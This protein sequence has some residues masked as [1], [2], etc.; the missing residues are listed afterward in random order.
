[1]LGLY[2]SGCIT[3]SIYHWI[4]ELSEMNHVI[5]TE[6]YWCQGRNNCIFYIGDSMYYKWDIISSIRYN[7]IEFKID[8][9]L[10]LPHLSFGCWGWSVWQHIIFCCR[11][12]DNTHQMTIYWYRLVTYPKL[13]GVGPV[14]NR[15]STD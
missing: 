2:F 3:G 15:P 9:N 4:W 12:P 7:M 8:S 10:W 5:T 14:D 13:D 11:G 6:A 1:M